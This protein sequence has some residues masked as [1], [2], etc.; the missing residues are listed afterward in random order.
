MKGWWLYVPTEGEKRFRKTSI[1]LTYTTYSECQKLGDNTA[2]IV[3]KDTAA[4][5]G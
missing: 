4:N 3:D 2:Y 1:K 5:D